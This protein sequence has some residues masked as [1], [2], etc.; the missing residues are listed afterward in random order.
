MQLLKDD[1]SIKLPNYIQPQ[2]LERYAKIDQIFKELNIEK[3]DR[4]GYLVALASNIARVQEKISTE[5]I[6]Q[7][8]LDELLADES[9]I[10][11]VAQKF[12]KEPSTLRRWIE[13][14][15]NEQQK[16]S[17]L[18]DYVAQFEQLARRSPESVERIALSIILFGP[19]DFQHRLHRISKDDIGEIK[20]ILNNLKENKDTIVA[21]IIRLFKLKSDA[22]KDRMNQA[23]EMAEQEGFIS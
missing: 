9:V 16:G 22:V 8:D 18:E 7:H 10:Q 13:D 14:I 4:R 1:S 17:A 19:E 5:F 21:P 20:A 6:P 15:K 23:L 2:K 3:G 11:A 12:G